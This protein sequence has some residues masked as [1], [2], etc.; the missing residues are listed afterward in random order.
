MSTEDYLKVDTKTLMK[1]LREFSEKYNFWYSALLKREIDL[2]QKNAELYISFKNKE[3][4][5]TQKEIE[6]LIMLDEEY[7]SKKHVLVEAETFYLMFKTNYNNKQTE[8]SLL[9]SELK[10]ELSF[11]ARER[12]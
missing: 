10:R 8:I 4:K 2:K 1:E 5:M 11:V 9:Q 7:K 6:A 12:K 3:E